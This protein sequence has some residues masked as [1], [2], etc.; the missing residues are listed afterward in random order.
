MTN[1]FRSNTHFLFEQTNLN[2][3]E[4]TKIQ[5]DDFVGHGV[6]KHLMGRGVSKHLVGHGISKHLV[7]H[8]VG[9]HLVINSHQTAN[10]IL[11]KCDALSAVYN[12]TGEFC[13]SNVHISTR[14][15]LKIKNILSDIKI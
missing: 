1:S 5:I 12:C 9:K 15:I 4:Q 7:G 3:F 14:I 2:K 11:L 6:V 8:G 13:H 10:T